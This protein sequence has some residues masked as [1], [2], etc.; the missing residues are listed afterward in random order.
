[1][2]VF[3]ATFSPDLNSIVFDVGGALILVNSDLN[4]SADLCE[5]IFETDFIDAIGGL[6]W[7]TC[8]VDKTKL[9]ANLGQN[10]FITDGYIVK[11]K[12]N[13]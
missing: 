11:F 8:S 4:N 3:E 5:K 6:R 9:F 12:K 2:G 13:S 10:S 7:A 1:M